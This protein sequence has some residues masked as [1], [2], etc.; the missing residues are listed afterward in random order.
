MTVIK[1]T[2]DPG[3]FPFEI[4]NEETQKIE[5][6]TINVIEVVTVLQ[7]A[8]QIGDGGT[9]ELPDQIAAIRKC[10]R[11]KALVERLEDHV[12]VGKF[13]AAQIQLDQL[14]KSQGWLQNLRPPTESPS[15]RPVSLKA[16]T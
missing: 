6:L 5:V 4:L 10:A 1:A 14:G 9:I 7:M 11:P 13:A 15:V 16:N 12:L 3:E 2:Q 8:G